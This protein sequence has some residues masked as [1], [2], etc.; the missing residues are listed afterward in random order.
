[1][2]WHTALLLH[3]NRSRARW[4]FQATQVAPEWQQPNAQNSAIPLWRGSCLLYF[5]VLL[6]GFDHDFDR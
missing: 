4:D 6:Y 5:P 1:M 2:S 3:H